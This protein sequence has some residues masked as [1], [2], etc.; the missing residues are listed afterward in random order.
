MAYCVEWRLLGQAERL[1]DGGRLGDMYPTYGHAAGAVSEFL[2]SYPQALRSED[3]SHWCA[4]RS[5]DADIELRV[6]IADAAR[7]EVAAA[8]EV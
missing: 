7:T 4:R 1:L 6:W 5:P 3:G 2:R 8:C